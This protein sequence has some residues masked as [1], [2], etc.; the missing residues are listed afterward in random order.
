MHWAGWPE[1]FDS[2]ESAD[3]VGDLG[4]E[5][6]QASAAPAPPPPAEP[7]VLGASGDVDPAAEQQRAA[8]AAEWC[9]AAGRGVAASLLRTTR[10]AAVSTP[11]PH[12]A[13]PAVACDMVGWPATCS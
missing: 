13:L 7:Y 5:F 12:L 3:N 10:A 2:W 11:T 8:D 1:S 6:D 9:D 4:L